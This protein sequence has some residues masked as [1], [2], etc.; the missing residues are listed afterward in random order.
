MKTPLALLAALALPY[1]ADAASVI[2]CEGIDPTH[3]PHYSLE[4]L[5][6]GEIHEPVRIGTEV[7]LILKKLIRVN[8][9]G[10]TYRATTYLTGRFL[11]DS[12]PRT[13]PTGGYDLTLFGMD[14]NEVE[15]EYG[16]LVIKRSLTE[17]RAAELT[18]LDKPS[19]DPVEL[20]CKTE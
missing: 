11:A 10:N 16:H 15:R 14:E 13:T 7:N 12:R 18:F 4:V 9:N 17:S 5:F 6:R 2:K 19:D 20:S 1:S 3:L 8:N